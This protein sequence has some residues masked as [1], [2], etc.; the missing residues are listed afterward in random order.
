MNGDTASTVVTD[1]LA[2]CQNDVLDVPAEF[3]WEK[4]RVTP[5]SST[6]GD[7]V[8]LNLRISRGVSN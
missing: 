5:V 7:A 4:S 2:G 3:I 1:R 6:R 8:T